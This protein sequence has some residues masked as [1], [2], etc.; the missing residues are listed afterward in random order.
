MYIIVL[1]YDIS[2]IFQIMFILPRMSL[3]VLGFP[4]DCFTPFILIFLSYIFIVEE[5][6]I[7]QNFNTI[8]NTS[9]KTKQ[10]NDDNRSGGVPNVH[11]LPGKEES[12]NYNNYDILFRA[13]ILLTNEILTNILPTNILLTNILF[14]KK[15]THQY[16]T[17]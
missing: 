3:F 7:D 8:T 17:N 5:T 6:E 16:I 4:Q 11:C 14:T 9:A 2:I 13:N 1:A 12:C 15:N 10:K